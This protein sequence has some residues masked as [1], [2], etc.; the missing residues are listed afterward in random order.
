MPENY[1]NVAESYALYDT[2]II[3]KELYG[4]EK[5]IPGWFYTFRDFAANDKHVFFKNRTIGNSHLAYCNMDS[6][7]NV[8]YVFNAISFGVRFFAPVVH[9]SLKEVLT[10]FGPELINENNPCFWLFDLPKHCGIDF[11]VQQDVIVENNCMAT[12]PGYGPRLGSGAQP[13]IYD[14]TDTNINTTPFKITIGT[15]GEPCIENRF[16]FAI[17]VRIPRNATI[18]ANVILSPYIRSI[19]D[20]MSGPEYW[21]GDGALVAETPANTDYFKV[22]VRYGIQVSLYGYREVQQRGQYHAPGAI[23]EV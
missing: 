4:K 12:P 1:L 22:P 21:V 14:P 13:I 18:E 3:C 17:P 19:M 2:I 11:R 10:P 7:D 9:D 16:P 6:A 5:T 20:N 8:D 15:M 23:Q